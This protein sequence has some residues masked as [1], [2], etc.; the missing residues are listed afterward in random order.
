MAD[1]EILI[2]TEGASQSV[3]EFDKVAKGLDK[4]KDATKAHGAETE[5]LTSK[6][7]KLIAGFKALGHEIPLVSTLLH[8]AKN[9]YTLL[10]VGISAV[11]AIVYQ[12]I[13]SIDAMA[14]EINKF[15]SIRLALHNWKEV[16]AQAAANNQSF[17]ESINAIIRSL[18]TAEDRFNK[19]KDKISK[20]FGIE[21]QLAEKTK[22]LE[23]AHIDQEV[24]AGRMTPAQGVA[25]KAGID[26][27]FGA[28]ARD[29]AEREVTARQNAA[30]IAN[31]EAAADRARAESELPGL[32]AGV[33][34]A[35]RKLQSRQAFLAA[36]E[37]DAADRRMK[38]LAAR[39]KYE[40]S[41]AFVGGL[42]GDFS[43][44]G[45]DLF[46]NKGT[47]DEQ[48]RAMDLE[49]DQARAG[50]VNAQSG[51]DTATGARNAVRGRVTGAVTSQLNTFKAFKEEGANLSRAR[52]AN[53]LFGPIDIATGRTEA[54]AAAAKEA[55]ENQRKQ[56]ERLE[57]IIHQILGNQHMS[58]ATQ[59]NIMRESAT[60]RAEQEKLLN[61]SKNA[62]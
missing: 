8:A 6:K 47:P 60:I 32:D 13:E 7:S 25:A 9:S 36:L 61:R 41:G 31:Q 2:K 53:Q 46:R 50:V 58:I 3:Q 59:Q 44:L 48:L 43:S 5:V 17:A 4:A 62:Q 42:R 15:E 27:R 52:G 29:R 30:A 23:H 33:K 24:A 1:F 10:G 22:G 56:N 18:D 55:L 57:E 37:S 16:A 49:L 14:K 20:T 45:S 28:E 40:E 19:T 38:I 34:E 12:F 26:E 21:S 11:V 39:E 51:F 54:G 35:G